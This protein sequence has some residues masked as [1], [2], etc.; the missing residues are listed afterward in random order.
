MR[1]FGKPRSVLQTLSQKNAKAVPVV[2][3]DLV[4]C[5]AL[6]TLIIHAIARLCANAAETKSLAAQ[7][8]ALWRRLVAAELRVV[9]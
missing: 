4:I 6:P 7:R 8:D 1:H 5:S 9:G 2:V 3:P